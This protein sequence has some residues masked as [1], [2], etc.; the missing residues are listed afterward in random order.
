[1]TYD[2][3]HHP[4]AAVVLDEYCE[5]AIDTMTTHGGMM[6]APTV[7]MFSGDGEHLDSLQG[8]V[9]ARPSYSGG[10]AGDAIRQLGLLPGVLRCDRIVIAWE[11]RTTATLLGRGG[12]HQTGIAAV[13]ATRNHRVVTW[14]PFTVHRGDYGIH[15]TRSMIATW[16]RAQELRTRLPV[17]ISDALRVW[18]DASCASITSTV[19]K[20]EAAG[21]LVSLFHEGW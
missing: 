20:L 9:I 10:D 5:Q 8:Y 21:Y 12:D 7:Y 15:G 6:P 4:A 17:P 2:D 11:H 16:G 14:R 13:E 3:A 1:M 19:A 18:T